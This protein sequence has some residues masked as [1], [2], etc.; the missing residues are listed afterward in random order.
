MSSRGLASVAVAV[1]LLAMAARAGAQPSANVDDYVLLATGTLK[2][3]GPTIADGDVGVNDAGG[4][5]ISRGPL[6]A[7]NSI[8]ASDQVRLDNVPGNTVA[9]EL[10]ANVVEVGGTATP[11]SPPLVADVPGACGFPSP[12]PACAPGMDVDVAAGTTTNLAPGTY[13]KVRVHGSPL[14][15]GVLVLTG[16]SYVVCDLKAS[17]TAQVRV[18]A[19]ATLAVVGKISLG[20][21]AV[22]G[23]EAGSGLVASDVHVYASGPTVKL[24]RQSHAEAHL[25]A[26]S[27]KLKMSRGGTHVG[28]FVASYIRT[29]EVTLAI[30]SPSGAYL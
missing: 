1:S 14:A 25:C 9:Q 7:P 6:T 30:G 24:A 21:G 17:R 16:G 27:A 3:K 22:L 18:Q 20:P 11:F 23:P 10:F 4:R 26:P 5:L 13:G 29:Q 19:P 8:V 15:A 12:F 2:T 28:S